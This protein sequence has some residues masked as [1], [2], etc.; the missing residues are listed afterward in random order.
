MRSATVR[1]SR[2]SISPTRTR[3]PSIRSPSPSTKRSAGTRH[4]PSLPR[5]APDEMR[6]CYRDEDRRDFVVERSIS[7]WRL[8]MRRWTAPS[9]DQLRV[10]LD[11]ELSVSR[12]AHR[13]TTDAYEARRW[14][15][16]R[17]EPIAD[18]LWRAS[19]G[20]LDVSA[21]YAATEATRAGWRD[22]GSRDPRRVL[23]CGEQRARASQPQRC[24]RSAAEHQPLVSSAYAEQCGSSQAVTPWD[25]HGVWGGTGRAR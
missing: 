3:Q 23:I 19:D 14:S 22:L 12:S 11:D 1:C 21:R 16:G 8:L 18:D 4:A 9:E 24:S 2:L 6:S 25:G 15:P 10:R 5:S 13:S 20:Y 7:A 17:L